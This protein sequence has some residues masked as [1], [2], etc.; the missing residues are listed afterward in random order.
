M[1]II[2]I[3]ELSIQTIIGVYAWEREAPR[4]LLID[5]DLG[6]DIRPAASNDQLELTF[7]YAKVAQRIKEDAAQSSYQLVE[8]LAERIAELVLR[9]FSVCWLR[10]CLRKP[11]VLPDAREVGILIERGKA[12]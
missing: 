7:D 5:L 9:E 3:R 1:D 8:T 4:T 12:F 11:G 2:F 6:T 10:L